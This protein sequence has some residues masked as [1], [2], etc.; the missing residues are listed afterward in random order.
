MPPRVL[1]YGK[2]G[3]NGVRRGDPH[4][5]VS[6]A[7]SRVARAPFICDDQVT[8]DANPS[9]L[10]LWPLFGAGDDAGPL[11]PSPDTPVSARPL[12]NLSLALNYHFGGRD[13]T[14]YHVA[15]IALH[16][17]ST[18]LLWALVNRTLRLDFFDRRYERVAGLLSF[19]SALVWGL[20]PLNTESVAY[21]TQRTE[22]MMGLLYMATIY[23]S[24]RY[25]QAQGGA[26]RA[27]WLALATVAC[28]AGAL[29]KEM[30]VSAPAVALAYERTFLS[31]SFLRPCAV[32]GRCTWAC[33][34]R[35]FRSS[36][37]IS[38]ALARRW[39]ASTLECPRT[40]GG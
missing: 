36:P 24:L 31:G 3:A 1:L 14:G 13:A 5:A 18:L 16:V 32:R 34:Y 30:I 7:Y 25:W 11:N 15:N 8:I 12:V 22:S 20:H 29:S 21:V 4:G 28:L 23:C 10:R 9:L 6:L 27:G 39:P 26:S 19:I 33:S 38:M 2:L 35:G 37:S 17:L 40:S